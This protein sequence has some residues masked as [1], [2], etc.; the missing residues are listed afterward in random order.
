LTH[1]TT[2]NGNLVDLEDLE[3]RLRALMDE[4]NGIEQDEEED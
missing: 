2:P 4:E 1:V 3:K